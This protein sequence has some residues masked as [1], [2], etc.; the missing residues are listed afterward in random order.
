MIFKT[1]DEILQRVDTITSPKVVAVPGAADEHT[2]QAVLR[3]Y[4]NGIVVPCLIGDPKEINSILEEIGGSELSQYIVAADSDEACAQMAVDFAREGKAQLLMKGSL[5]SSDYLRPIVSSKGGLKKR[6]T[7]SSISISSCPAY[8]KVYMMTDCGLLLKPTLEQKKDTIINAVEV[9]RSLGHTED[10]KVAVLASAETVNP[11]LPETVD[12]A[13]LKSMNQ[14]GEIRD[15]IVEGP[16]SFD[17]ATDADAVKA[18]GYESPVAGDADIFIV[19]D[20]AC[21]NI[22]G[23]A[24]RWAGGHGVN[25]IGGASVPIAL[26]SRGSSVEAKYD[27]L[28]FSALAA[29]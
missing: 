12:G 9:L 5:Q 3:A 14:R 24:L 10:I 4:K 29:N 22:L 16:I 25:F 20:L 21:G 27:I 26:A 19:P 18:K 15:C 2:L 8:H 23:K 6:S 28:A 11:K 7:L 1:I 17:L 13:E